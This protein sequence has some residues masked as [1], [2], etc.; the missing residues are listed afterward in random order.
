MQLPVAAAYV[1][2]VC[3]LNQ[4]NN[5]LATISAVVSTCL[6]AAL[7]DNYKLTAAG[8]FGGVWSTVSVEVIDDEEEALKEINRQSELEQQRRNEATVNKHKST[9]FVHNQFY[10]NVH[11]FCYASIKMITY[12]NFGTGSRTR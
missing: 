10:T 11:F 3:C 2:V 4:V 12:T 1:Q 7:Y 6:N 8:A 5:T 9:S